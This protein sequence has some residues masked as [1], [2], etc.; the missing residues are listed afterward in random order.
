[1]SGEILREPEAAK[2]LALS[3]SYLRQARMASSR[4]DGPP[5]VRFGRAVGYRRADLDVWVARHLAERPVA[6]A[7]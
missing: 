7:Q 5:F 4:V 6:A 3:R 2:Y 1:M